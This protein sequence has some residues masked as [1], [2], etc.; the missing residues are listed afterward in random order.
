MNL[1]YEWRWTRGGILQLMVLG[2]SVWILAVGL[3]I[4]I[5]GAITVSRLMR[6]F[7]FGI[8]PAD[9]LN[10]SSMAAILLAVAQIAIYVPARR[11]MKVDPSKLNSYSNVRFR[12]RPKTLGA[13]CGY[14]QLA[15]VVRN[16]TVFTGL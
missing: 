8:S 15:V 9:P 13:A 10:L 12:G 2:Q 6:S 3:T 5:A 4:G 11:A 14:L 16:R 1:A 7:L